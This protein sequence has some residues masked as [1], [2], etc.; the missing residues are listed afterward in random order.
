M[1]NLYQAPVAP[2]FMNVFNSRNDFVKPP[3]VLVIPH[4]LSLKEFIPEHPNCWELYKP[5]QKN[6]Y[7]ILINA[8]KENSIY[9]KT[10][11]MPF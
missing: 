9:I 8:K 10:E 5:N 2:Q 1:Y 4:V 7:F 6:V 11:I 3:Y